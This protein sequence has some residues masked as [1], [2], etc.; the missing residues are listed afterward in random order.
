MVM[1]S[2]M[3]GTLYVLITLILYAFVHC[4]CSCYKQFYGTLYVRINMYMFFSSPP[5]LRALGRASCWALLQA[6]C[7]SQYLQKLQSSLGRHPCC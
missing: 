3:Y 4:P 1:M 7:E 5:K 6:L 2:C